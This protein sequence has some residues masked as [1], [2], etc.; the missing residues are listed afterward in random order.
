VFAL[1]LEIEHPA[2]EHHEGKVIQTVDPKENTCKW[3]DRVEIRDAILRV[4][5]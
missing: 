4:P 2:K 1:P 3:I 5:R